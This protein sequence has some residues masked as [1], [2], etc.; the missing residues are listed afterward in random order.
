MIRPTASILALISVFFVVDIAYAQRNATTYQTLLSRTRQANTYIDVNAAPLQGRPDSSLVRTNFRLEYDY[1]N[2]TRSAAE[3]DPDAEFGTE[4]TIFVDVYK[5]GANISDRTEQPDMAMM[6]SGMPQRRPNPNSNPAPG[7]G[8]IPLATD[9]WR[10]MAKAANYAQT[11]SNR[12]YLEGFIDIGLPA[13]DYVFAVSMREEG[14]SRIR[15]IGRARYRVHNFSSLEARLPIYVIKPVSDNKTNAFELLGYGTQIPYGIDFDV[16]I[17]ISGSADPNTLTLFV[18]GLEFG[19]R[20]TSVTQTLAT[21]ETEPEMV[22]TGNIQFGSGYAFDLESNNQ[23]WL[24]V[25]VLGSR[26]PNAPIRIEL[27]ANGSTTPLA[28]RMLQ[29]KWVDIPTSLLNVSVAVDMMESILDKDEFR[30]V[31]RLNNNEKEAYFKDYWNPKD[32]TPGT[33]FNELMVEYYRRVDIAYERFTSAT[34]PGFASDQGKTFILMG[35]PDRIT[36]RFP[37]DQPALEIWEYGDR[38]IMF[39]ATSGFGDF[40]LVSSSN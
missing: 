8:A 25:P 16:L 12:H 5:A 18:K 28:Q 20:D 6:R 14:Q 40:K 22:V 37:P 23:K 7:S 17:P 21:I 11:I 2:F 13:G 24:R 9:A 32:P 31:R 33:E 3:S 10:G 15:P 27:I 29:S 26:F 35:E 36:R 39:Q 19:R 1:L 30:R 34:T 38:Q 4:V